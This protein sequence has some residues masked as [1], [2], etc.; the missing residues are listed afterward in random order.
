MIGGDENGYV[1]RN[2]QFL[3]CLEEFVWDTGG[4]LWG[5]IYLYCDFLSQHKKLF[6]S[7]AYVISQAGMRCLLSIPQDYESGG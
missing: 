7:Y 3:G 4:A 2:C 1:V 6:K 5:I